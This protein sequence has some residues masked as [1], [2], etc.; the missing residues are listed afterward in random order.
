[1]NLPVDQADDNEREDILARDTEERVAG[2]KYKGT[3][4]KTFTSLTSVSDPC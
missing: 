4:D 1:M 3:A 2:P